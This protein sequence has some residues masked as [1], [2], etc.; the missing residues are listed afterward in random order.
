MITIEFFRGYWTLFINEVPTLS[1]ASFE[2]AMFWQEE[3]A[4]EMQ[5]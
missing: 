4:K 5:S 1:C 2:R 3:L